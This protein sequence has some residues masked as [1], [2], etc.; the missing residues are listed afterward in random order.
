MGKQPQRRPKASSAM[1]WGCEWFRMNPED[2][3]EEKKGM[4]RKG[5]A[6]CPSMRGFKGG[7]KKRRERNGRGDV[8]PHDRLDLSIS[9]ILRSGE[10]G[11]E[12]KA[13]D[14]GNACPR[15]YI[16]MDHFSTGVSG[17][18]ETYRPPVRKMAEMPI[19]RRR[20]I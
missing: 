15:S 3:Q 19:L 20:E 14:A 18:R 13:E 8:R 2:E 7:K 11:D 10:I 5:Q 9:I 17:A 12:D 6:A 4:A 1:L 16:S